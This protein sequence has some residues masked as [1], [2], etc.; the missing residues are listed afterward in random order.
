MG[1]KILV[2]EDSSVIQNITRKVLQ[3]QNYEI[4]S[5][6]NGQQVLDKLEKTDFDA[7]LLDIN[8][9]V[10][11]GME[12]AQKIRALDDTSKNSVPIVAITGNA[13][14]YSMDD[15]KAVGINEYLPKPLN[16]DNLVNVVNKVTNN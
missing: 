4:I 13:K 12:C 1:K 8:M 15:F 11:D 14:N 5:V 7:I 9:P 10:M 3:F 2:A 6:K 16:F